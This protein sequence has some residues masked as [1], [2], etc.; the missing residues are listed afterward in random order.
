MSAHGLRVTYLW[1]V[2]MIFIIY[3]MKTE[4]LISQ[5]EDSRVG[6]HVLH[7]SFFLQAQH[8]NLND[9]KWVF[10]ISQL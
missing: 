7:I 4:H 10:T 3:L 8:G 5:R 9:L 1:I 6:V 2:G